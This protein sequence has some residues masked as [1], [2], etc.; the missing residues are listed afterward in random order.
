MCIEIQKK[1]IHKR[2]KKP[3]E[4]QVVREG[5]LGGGEGERESEKSTRRK[6]KYKNYMTVHVNG[7]NIA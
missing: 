3:T 1:N 7:I 4:S 6:I 2:G 5:L